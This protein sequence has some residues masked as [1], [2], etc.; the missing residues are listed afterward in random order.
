LAS[1]ALLDYPTLANKAIYV[2]PGDEIIV[3]ARKKT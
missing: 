1:K 3:Y 2:N